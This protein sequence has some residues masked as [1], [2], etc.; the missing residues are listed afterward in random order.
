MLVWGV[1]ALNH[2]LPRVQIILSRRPSLSRRADGNA[3]L[4]IYM[5]YLWNMPGHKVAICEAAR[6]NAPTP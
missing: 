3:R 6:R 1:P 5:I 4:A 2:Q